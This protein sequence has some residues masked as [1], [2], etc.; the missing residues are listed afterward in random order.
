MAQ[1]LV[2]D[3]IEILQKADPNL[4]IHRHKGG[5]EFAPVDID[6]AGYWLGYETLMVSKN[7]PSYVARKSDPIWKR[8]RRQF[9]KPF[10]AVVFW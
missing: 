10:K 3:L 1:M 8:V 2:K 4:P 9:S 5:G 7:D 6:Y